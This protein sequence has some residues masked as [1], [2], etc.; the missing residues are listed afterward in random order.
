MRAR[1]ESADQSVA[2]TAE[3]LAAPILPIIEEVDPQAAIEAGATATSL[4][5]EA[6]QVTPHSHPSKYSS[7]INFFFL[8]GCANRPSAISAAIGHTPGGNWNTS[9]P[10]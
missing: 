10:R 6:I 8:S 7:D 2:A 5:V 9:N 3:S 4:L 1:I